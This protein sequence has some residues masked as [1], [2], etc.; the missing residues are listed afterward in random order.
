MNPK[1]PMLI[2]ASFLFG[3]SAL[4]ASSGNLL[5][6]GTVGIVNDIVVT[7]VA[8]VNNNLDILA[9]ESNLKVADVEESSNNLTG[10]SISMSSVNA[11]TLVHNSD[12][13]KST[14]YTI[15]YDGATATAPT[16]SPAVVKN[17][18]SLTGFTQNFS[19][20]KINVTA[21]PSAPVGVYSDT[22][23]FAISANP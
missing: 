18:A 9:G 4:A 16:A 1:M 20:V 14:P 10:Y 19:E 8:G 11:G 21:Y 12:N 23:T 13:T 7:P 17:V 2:L 3:I 22:I 5:V 6:Q 15:S